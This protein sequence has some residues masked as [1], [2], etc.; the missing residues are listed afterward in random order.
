MARRMSLDVPYACYQ[1]VFAEWL[2]E[3]GGTA[4][5]CKRTAS[6]LLDWIAQLPADALP[7][8]RLLI[9]PCEARTSL[10]A[11]CDASGT[12]RGAGRAAFVEDVAAQV[13]LFAS[14]ACCDTVRL[15]LEVVRGDACRR[16]HRDCVPLRLIC[17]YRGPA[18]Q[19][20]PPELANAPMS[21]PDDDSPHARSLALGDVAIFKGCGWPGLAHDGGIV[22]RSPRI[23]STGQTRLV[24]VL[25]IDAPT[26]HPAG[27]GQETAP[28]VDSLLISYLLAHFSLALSR[29][30]P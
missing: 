9:Q 11:V 14:L 16:W 21:A 12:P 28:D 2:E 27:V 13:A 18:A 23:S 8:G 30:L 24:L 5:L 22:H 26:G 6:P 1:E 15:R 10:N 7:A 19:W 17:T 20:V 3:T 25:V 29:F 4:A